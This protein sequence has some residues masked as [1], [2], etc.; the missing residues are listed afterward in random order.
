MSF[1]GY[2]HARSGA[3]FGA[4]TVLVLSTFASACSKPTP[5]PKPN[6]VLISIDTLRADHLGVYGYP[7]PTSP[8][9]DELAAGGTTFLNA[10]AHSSYTPPSQTSLLTSVHPSVHGVWFHN[11]A[12]SND[13]PM[14]AEFFQQAGYDTG[15][16][17]ELSFSATH[18][19][20]G[21]DTYRQMKT[22]H[23]N[24]SV[25]KTKRRIFSWLDQRG[26]RPY[27]LFLH[28]F[29]VHLPY[30]PQEEYLRMFKSDYDG[31]VGDTMSL[32]QLE[33]IL[34]GD[35]PVRPEDWDHIR[36]LY[37]AGIAR[38]D[39]FLGELFDRFRAD[40]SFD[41]T[42]FAIVSDH[43]EQFG[44][45]GTHGHSG[46]M[47]EY[48]IRTPLILTGPGVPTGQL[49]QAP[50]RNIDVAPTLLRLAGLHPPAHYEGADLAPIWRNEE[51][52]ER[53]VVAEKQCCRAFVVENWKYAVILETGEDTLFDLDV[54]PGETTNLIDVMPEMATQMRGL[55]SEWDTQL[56][57]RRD[58]VEQGVEVTLTDEEI[59]RLKALGYLQ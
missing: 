31:P 11:M 47:W 20:R 7:K 6:V 48:I 2:R 56:G 9:L 13:A 3:C 33:L 49:L 40:G 24:N 34:D 59:R 30:F 43:G 29:W 35:V 22:L 4:A 10:Y 25:R 23:S 51:T 38:L 41:S 57:K 42:V 54:D 32:K 15:A 8:R 52:E 50:A 26:E 28:F 36:A 55:A 19:K 14:L 21:F 1:L 18:Y 53:V 44:E 16:W 5:A 46:P 58:Q 39:D 27:F 12:A 17:A 45:H 37:D